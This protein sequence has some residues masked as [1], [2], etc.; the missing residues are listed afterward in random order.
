MTLG[1]L[2]V[3]FQD[4]LADTDLNGRWGQ[5]EITRFINEGQNQLALSIRWP[6]GTATNTT[7]SG[8]QEYTLPESILAVRRVYIAGQQLVPT[9]IAAMEG[10]MTELYDQSGTNYQPEWQTLDQTP[11]S[12]PAVYPVAN[13]MIFQPF[14]IK[15]GA[16]GLLR[17]AYYFRG[18]NIGFVPIPAGAYTITLHMIPLPP[19]LA[20]SAD[21]CLFPLI[22]RYAI[23]HK[24]VQLAKESDR[25]YDEAQ[26][27]EEQFDKALP[28]L[29]A[30]KR[31]FSPAQN[32]PMIRT[33]RTQYAR[34]LR[35]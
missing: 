28:K 21:N 12:N 8:V 24:A 30:W 20:N 10:I 26:Y 22:A 35:A 27:N 23:A 13:T 5:S 25:H 11:F 14:D 19:Q 18:M 33:Y 34:M 9:S 7:S 17:P 29:I 16:G 1:D 32:R 3:T 2:T 4:L 31:D 15:P 6:E